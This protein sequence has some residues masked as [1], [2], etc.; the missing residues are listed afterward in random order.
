MNDERVGYGKPP[1]QHRFK[2]G[3]SGNPR[4][5]P[6]KIKPVIRNTEADILKRLGEEKVMVQGKECTALEVEL[7]MLMAKALR[8][9]L[10][11]MKLLDRKREA[12]GLIKPAPLGG[13]LVV[14]EAPS[15]EDYLRRVS[16]NQRRYRECQSEEDK[17][18]D[19][20]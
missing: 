19:K 16:E 17:D 14:P 8:G 18:V 9:D 20:H 4:G 2:K 5:R 15:R 11:A 12:A 7:R 10:A 3:R 1:K 6:R 13:V